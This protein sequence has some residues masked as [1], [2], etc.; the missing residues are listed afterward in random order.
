MIVYPNVKI[1]IG[2]KITGKRNDGYHNL[3]T[4]YAPAAF[5]DILEIIPSG[6]KDRFTLS[7]HSVSGNKNEN[8]VIRALRIF[9]TEF[10]VPPVAIH[11]HKMIPEGS[12]LGG[13]SSDA[14]NTLL[15]LNN[16]FLAGLSR[17]KLSSMA[18][19]LGSDCPFYIYNRLAF[20]SGRGEN[21]RPVKTTHGTFGL[22]II[23]PPIHISTSEAFRITPIDPKVPSPFEIFDLPVP[24]WKG[25][26]INSFETVIRDLYP[27]IDHLINKL[28]DCG[29]IYASLSGSGSAVYGIFNDRD[30]PCSDFG[31]TGLIWQGKT[32]L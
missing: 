25:K 6:K 31:T 22:V 11:L 23:I 29:A 7:G 20:A 8:L 30:I 26:M 19:M 12:G 1:N 2:L 24:N 16:M 28:Y 27:Q 3:E 18:A 17:K 9:R 4:I 5:S 32:E 10:P 13:G 21:I 14:T 15:L